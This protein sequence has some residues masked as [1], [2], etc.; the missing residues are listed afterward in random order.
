ME[1]KLIF[2]GEQYLP[3]ARSRIK[4]MRANG[5]QYASQQ[6]EIDGCAIK[7]RIEG[8]HEYITIGGGGTAYMETGQLGWAIPGEYVPS[9]YDAAAWNFID[10]PHSAKYLGKIATGGNDVGK[11]RNDPPLS[12]ATPSIAVGPPR[13]MYSDGDAPDAAEQLK[14]AH[15]ETTVSRKRME[16]GIPPSFFSGKMRL[17]IQALYG[18]KQEDSKLTQGGFG[19]IYTV[20]EKHIDLGVQPDRSPGIYTSS[21]G[22]YWLIIL[23]LRPGGI[24]PTAYAVV[25]GPAAAGLVSRMRRHRA[26]KLVLS[27]EEVTQTEAYIF[28]CCTVDVEH[29]HP[30]LSGP[31]L[32]GWPFAYGWKWSTSGHKASMVTHAEVLVDGKLAWEAKTFHLEFSIEKNP[33]TGIRSFDA[34]ATTVVHGK[35]SD[36]W[37]I[38]TIFAPIDGLTSAPLQLQ[39]INLDPV[40]RSAPFDFTVD[41]YGYYRGESWTPIT[42]SRRTPVGPFPILSQSS[43]G[44]TYPPGQDMTVPDVHSYGWCPATEGNTVDIS[45]YYDQTTVSITFGGWTYLSEWGH[46]THT[47]L[48][49]TVTGAGSAEN[50]A[51]FNSHVVGGGP[52][53]APYPAG[54]EHTSNWRDDGIFDPNNPYI[55]HRGTVSLCLVSRT[56][57]TWT[58]DLRKTWSILIPGGDCAAVY[59]STYKYAVADDGFSS[60]TWYGNPGVCG[61]QGPRS[62]FVPYAGAGEYNSYYG[63]GGLNYWDYSGSLATS[64]ITINAFS[65]A[66]HGTEGVLANPSGGWQ[67]YACP[68]EYPFYDA[69]MWAYT[70][71][72]GRYVM[73]EGLKS[74]P[75]LDFS[76]RFVGWA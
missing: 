65:Q 72:G 29:P 51:D 8:A 25:P 52:F 27:D 57:T 44:L 18:A 75:T 74:Y 15:G 33:E 64:N 34:S 10:I 61:F 66:V 43:T 69:G 13:Y 38:N 71:Y 9:R 54:Y 48:V 50:A 32:N 12:S 49:K 4:A 16:V 53:A 26:G 67:M 20:K 14:S 39:S 23:T 58:G 22:S 7:L 56:E 6:F 76:H 19:L 41:I 55:G 5:A 42:I 30:M 31:A 60:K 37:P 36:S 73:S 2:G 63:F 17:F 70:S 46:G 3:F 45:Y 62:S 68:R 40:T 11:Q 21:D 59:I 1:H 24:S 28:S 35:W 47:H